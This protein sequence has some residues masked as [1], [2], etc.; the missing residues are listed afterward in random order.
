MLWPTLSLTHEN[1]NEI[2][3]YTVKPLIS[4]HLGISGCP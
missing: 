3:P 1:D 2:I 4:G